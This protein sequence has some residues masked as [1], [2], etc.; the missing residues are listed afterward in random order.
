MKEDMTWVC[1]ACGSEK[2]EITVWADPNTNQVTDDLGNDETFCN[3]CEEHDAGIQTR[4]EWL[5]ENPPEQASTSATVVQSGVVLIRCWN[6]NDEVACE[7]SRIVGASCPGCS[8][9]IARGPI[10]VAKAGEVP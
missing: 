4:A 10:D 1:C 6:C 9:T 2:V 5:E 7:I 3:D 8:E